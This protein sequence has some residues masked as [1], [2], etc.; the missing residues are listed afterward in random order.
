MLYMHSIWA[1]GERTIFYKNFTGY[2]KSENKDSERVSLYPI[3]NDDEITEDSKVQILEVDKDTCLYYRD[4][5]VH[6]LGVAK[7]ERYYLMMIDNKV[8]TAFGLHDREFN[9]MKSNYVDEVFGISVSSKKYKRLGKLFMM[10]L[11]SGDFK[12]HLMHKMNLGIR[13]LKGIKTSSKTSHHEGK[14]DRGVMRLIKREEQANGTFLVVYVG[15][16]REDTYAD[17][18]KK[19]LKQ[20]G[21]Y[22]RG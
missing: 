13:T 19:W 10:C 6:K 17:C 22:K 5:F 12:K 20:Y 4:L 3:F 11:T 7:A 16:F 9:A 2:A 18:V 14:T 8:V 21:Y 1:E 15:D